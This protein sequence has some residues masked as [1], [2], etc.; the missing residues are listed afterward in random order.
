MRVLSW[1]IHKGIGGVDRRYALGRIGAVIRH[2]DPDVAL[3]QEVDKAVPRT[4]R[5]DQAELLADTLG[6]PHV[7]FGDNVRLSE[8]RYGNATLSRFPIS[9]QRNINLKFSVKKKRGGLYTELHA[10]VN[11]RHRTLHVFNIHLGLSGVE[12]RWQIRRLLSSDPLAHLDRNSRIIIGGDTNDWSGALGR[13][14]LRK[15]GFL[16]ATGSGARA[17]AT[18]PAWRP[19][20]ALDRIFTRGAL[21]VHGHFG[22]RME[23]ARQASDHRPIIVD[24]ELLAR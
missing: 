14:Q 23:M 16:A 5:D 21:Q 19:V 8:G 13:G 10:R 20:G 4:R 18:F 24:C 6:F 9:E 7:A 12:R 3:L 15:A 2:Y 1:N 11:G 17:T 22:A